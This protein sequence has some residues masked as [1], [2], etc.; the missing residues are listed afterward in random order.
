MNRVK[1]PRRA[2]LGIP[3]TL[4]SRQL[5]HGGGEHHLTEMLAGL[6]RAT[7]QLS[8]KVSVQAARNHAPLAPR[9][10]EPAVNNARI[11]PDDVHIETKP[12]QDP[13][14][15]NR[16]AA[17][18]FQIVLAG[19]R[20]VVWQ[21]YNVTGLEKE[22]IHLGDGKFVGPYTGRTALKPNTNYVV[23]IRFKDSSGDRATQY[24][25]WATRPFRTT[26]GTVQAGGQGP[27]IKGW[28]VLRP[29]FTVEV[30]AE[31]FQLPVAI[32]FVPNPGNTANAPLYYVAELYGT[33]KMVQ[34]NGAVHTY[35]KDL[36]NFDPTGR[37]PGSGETG[38]AG[39]VVDPASGDLFATLLYS[40]AVGD[41][42]PKIIRLHSNDGGHTAASQAT[43]LNIATEVQGASHQISHIS[44][45]PDG[46]LYVHVGDGMAPGVARDLTQFRGKILRLNFDGSPSSDNPYY[47]P[48]DGINATDYIF[49]SGFR[50]PFGGAW[51]AKTNELYEVENGP[52]TDRLAVVVK[53]RDYGYNY[54]DASMKNFAVYNW[55]PAVAPVNIAFVQR[56]SQGGSKFP[57]GMQDHAF[58]T[59]SGPT[60]AT[61]PQSRGKR[62]V[63][64][65]FNEQGRRI[66]GPIPLLRYAGKG[67]ATAAALAAG[68][69]GLYFSELYAD[70]AGNNPTLPQARILRIRYVGTRAK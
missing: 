8:R 57:T 50:N 47:N 5:L 12:M 45:G 33:I 49:A 22:H 35:A 23:R 37:F 69:D 31:G 53:G 48:D 13:D 9:I 3:E 56:D 68:P 38:L 64:F 41:H 11:S 59:E 32:A 16:H 1:R 67:K 19:S 28:R 63:E 17:S 30:A 14:P 52:L 7:S 70:K 44:I 4:E 25:P 18:D 43:I 39:L 55:N 10:Q 66:S 15:G 21:S 54:S 2:F 6:E 36:L 58:V 60:F 61:G 62:V 26:Q 24:S 42:H 51:R 27:I 29:G 40:D 46:L 20:R 65:A 34:R